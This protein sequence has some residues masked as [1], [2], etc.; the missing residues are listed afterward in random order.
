MYT[1]F[2]LLGVNNIV[3]NPLRHLLL[4][5]RLLSQERVLADCDGRHKFAALVIRV[6]IP[7]LL[8]NIIDVHV[9]QRKIAPSLSL[10][11]F[12]PHALA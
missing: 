11:D 5:N 7:L 3:D 12:T 10:T 1:Y 2:F 9:L 8:W 6:A 4:A